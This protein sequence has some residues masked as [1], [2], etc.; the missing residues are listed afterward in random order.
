MRSKIR[1]KL[2][3]ITKVNI[4]IVYEPTTDRSHLEGILSYHGEMV[5]SSETLLDLCSKHPSDKLEVWNLRI[6]LT[7][8]NKAAGRRVE[9]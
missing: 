4:F 9:V 8:E 1:M 5:A 6:T 7:A 3:V 2:Q